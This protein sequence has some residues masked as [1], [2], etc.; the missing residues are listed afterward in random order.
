V[1]EQLREHQIGLLPVPLIEKDAFRALFAM[2]GDLK[3]LERHGVPGM[4][5]PA[6]TLR[7]TSIACSIR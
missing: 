1:I 4:A 7:P 2:G 5:A 3:A 6:K